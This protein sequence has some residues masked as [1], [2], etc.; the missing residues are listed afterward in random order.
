MPDDETNRRSNRRLE[1]LVFLPVIGA[2]IIVWGLAAFFKISERANDIE[3]ARTQLSITASTL[4]DFNQLATRAGITK[5]EHT[6]ERTQAIWN[7]FLQYPTSAF[8]V[9]DNGKIVDGHPPNN[10]RAPYIFVAETRGTLT[11]HAALPQA[12]ALA[13]WQWELM[14]GSGLL[15]AATLA[16]L[17]LTHLLARTL[18]QRGNAEKQAALA[19]DR[20]SQL[21]AFQLELQQTVTERTQDLREANSRLETELHERRVAEK[22][23][24]EHDALLNAVTKSASELLGSH[25]Y[26]DAVAAVLELIGQTVAV[27]RVQLIAIAA[28]KEGHMHAR[29]SQEWCA[30]GVTPAIDHP[31]FQDIDLTAHF[32]QSIAPALSGHPYSCTLDDIRDDLREQYR[33]LGMRSCL[34]IPVLIDGRLWGTLHFLDSGTEPRKWSWAETDGLET[35]AGLIGVAL[36]RARYVKELAD[37][38]MIVQ[39]SPTIL[40]RLRGEP[41]LSLAYISPNVTKFGHDPKKLMASTHWP[42]LMIDPADQ[43]R[44]GEAMTKTLQK[45]AGGGTIEF[46]LRTGDG[47]LRW[48]ENRYAPVRD[49]LGR[50]IEVEGIII[51]I[52]ERKI[53]EEKIALLARTDGLT[54]LANRNTFVDRLRQGFAASQRGGDAFAVLYLDVDHFKDVN[55]TLGH[56]VGDKLL[57]EIAE[58]L[59]ANTREYDVIARLG[60]DEFAILQTDLEDPSYAGDLASK[61]LR[62]LSAPYSLDGNDV[63]ITVSIGIAPYSESTSGPDAMLGQADL[64]LYRAKDQGRN[65]FRFHSEDLDEKVRDRVALT[66]ALREALDKEQL[67]LYYQPQVEVISGKIVGIEALVRWNHP[68]RGLLFPPDFLAAAEQTGTIMQLGHWVFDRACQQL[69]RWRDEGIAPRLL[70]INL[71][72]LQLKNARELTQDVVSTLQKWNLSASDIEFDVTEATLAQLKWTGSDVLTQLNRLGAQIA[73]DDFGTEYSSFDYLKSYNVSH[74][75]IARSLISKALTD[76]EGADMIR[77]MINLAKELGVGVMAEG[78]E[79]REQREL[80]ISTGTPTKA[81][82]FYFSEPVA[83]DRAGDLLRNRSIAPEDHNTLA[84]KKQAIT[85]HR[86]KD[87]H[88]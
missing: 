32:P 45:G 5:D 71:S 7:A 8:W 2:L 61:L 80:L 84:R 37:A 34:Q 66:T 76:P 16:F 22:A 43:A 9:I 44:F 19:E 40:Y 46:R 51:D 77:V 30:P 6:A 78:V 74:L 85:Q 1:R 86:E 3:Q 79:T 11:V 35:L 26:E 67:E 72:L 63:H 81:Q 41:S 18:R 23:L 38:N 28:D 59:R 57:K 53:A 31:L 12:D 55:D 64:A 60:G 54:S 65:Q 62:A 87:A 48:V 75:K 25:A 24:R 13:S 21:T 20:A 68:T 29:I 58:R 69:R 36:V 82:G 56:P 4:A 33:G 27:S 42:E 88:H 17:F 70:T 50:L 15:A 14:W 52:T 73:I 39:N 83:S 49:K 10:E 47:T